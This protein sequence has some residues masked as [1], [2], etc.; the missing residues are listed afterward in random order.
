MKYLFI[1]ICAVWG[2]S[3]KSQELAH[4]LSYGAQPLPNGLEWIETSV[5]TTPWRTYR[6]YIAKKEGLEVEGADAVV[7]FHLDGNIDFQITPE[8]P[9]DIPGAHPLRF[10]NHPVWLVRNGQWVGVE[11]LDVYQPHPLSRMRYWLDGTGRVIDSLDLVR[12]FDTAVTAKVFAPDPLSVANATYGGIYVDANDG[13]ASVLDSLRTSANV[14]LT[15]NGA[16]F[17]LANSAAII[18]EFDPPSVAVPVL[19][20]PNAQ[21][22]RS[23][24]EF[25]MVNVL[26]HIYEWKNRMA[27]L[28]YG[29]MVPYAIP[30][31]VNAY[32]G[33]DQ[34]AFDFATTPP[35]LF[36]GEGGVDDAEDADVII[37]EYGHAMAY[38]A[39]PGTNIGIQRQALEEAIC[40][41]W[42]VSWSRIQSPYKWPLVFTWDGH[43]EFWAGRSAVN[44]QQKMYPGL[45]F[46]GP[47]SH[48]SVLVDALVRGRQ[49]VGAEVMDGLVMEALYSLTSSTTFRQFAEGVLRADTMKYGGIHSQGLHTDFAAWQIL[50]PGMSL[51]E[52][53]LESHRTVVWDGFNWPEE[54]PEEVMVWDT[55]GRSFVL[56]R[57]AARPHSGWYFANSF[58]VFVTP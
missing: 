15:W 5:K 57:N 10:A 20:G 11:R 14:E 54:L 1:V 7:A 37:H 29:G 13:N 18:Q 28:G 49:R 32:G 6:R 4:R 33:A 3:A 12:R 55:S 19:P 22:S 44:T 56:R 52:S 41:Y 58:R 39:A 17:V 27:N 35:R 38:G 26:Y 47:Y 46:T 40:D 21:F 9:E 24:S 36:F 2:W 25:E 16:G 8:L 34:S 30:A 43:N 23:D 53:K 42:A 51:N 31:D 50:T 45:S 48:T